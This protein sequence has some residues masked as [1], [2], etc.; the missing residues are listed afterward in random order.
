MLPSEIKKTE[1]PKKPKSERKEPPLLPET[2]VFC[3]RKNV[4][5]S[6]KKPARR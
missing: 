3:Q 2:K 1:L 6:A 5:R 4:S